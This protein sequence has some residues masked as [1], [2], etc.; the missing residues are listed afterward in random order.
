MACR[1]REGP[2]QNLRS[3][4]SAPMR[5]SRGAQANSDR[6]EMRWANRSTMERQV[7]A[8]LTHHPPAH[9]PLRIEPSRYY[10]YGE[11]RVSLDGCVEVGRR[12]TTHQAGS[13]NASTCNGRICTSACSGPIGERRGWRRRT[14]N[15]R[16]KRRHSRNNARADF[17]NCFQTLAFSSAVNLSETKVAARASHRIC[18]TLLSSSLFLFDDMKAKTSRRSDIACVDQAR[19]IDLVTPCDRV[20]RTD[21]GRQLPQ[22][23]STIHRH[24]SSRASRTKFRAQLVALDAAILPVETARNPEVR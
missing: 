7:V 6:W 16:P 11:R 10:R 14:P 22:L 23:P 20:R 1:D 19:S 17:V 18:F 21:Q 24:R 4:P 13:P 9:R 8:T 2:T 15:V 5:E 3:P 12:T